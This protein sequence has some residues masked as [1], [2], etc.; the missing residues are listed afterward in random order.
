MRAKL[1]PLPV[2]STPFQWMALQKSLEI[3]EQNL[4]GAQEKKKIWHNKK[5]WERTFCPEDKVLML[6]P[7]KGNKLQLAWSR[8][9][10]VLRQHWEA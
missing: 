10:D 8:A 9:V 6:K 4:K 7:I 1:F 2:I 5:V 3:A